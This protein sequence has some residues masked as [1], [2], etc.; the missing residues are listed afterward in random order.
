MGRLDARLLRVLFGAM[1]VGVLVLSLLPPSAGSV[2]TVGWDK[3]N[4]ASAFFALAVLGLG[5]YPGRTAFVCAGLLGYGVLVEL[6]QGTTTWRAAEAA[7]LLADAIGIAVGVVAVAMMRR[8]GVSWPAAASRD[9]SRRATAGR[10][11]TA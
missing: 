4:H 7:D 11:P 8:A 5:G 2:V 6:L 3:A 1:M 10:P 9:A